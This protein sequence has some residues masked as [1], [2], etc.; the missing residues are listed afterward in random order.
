MRSAQGSVWLP[1]CHSADRGPHRALRHRIPLLSQWPLG[2]PCL[3]Q[4][5]CANPITCTIHHA[6]PTNASIAVVVS[7][8]KSETRPRT[9]TRSRHLTSRFTLAVEHTHTRPRRR[10]SGRIPRYAPFS[11][12]S[13][14]INAP[15]AS[16]GRPA[17]LYSTCLL[18]Y[19]PHIRR[20]HPPTHTLHASLP[21]PGIGILY[22]T[23]PATPARSHP[24]TR[25]P[26]HKCLCLCL[27]TYTAAIYIR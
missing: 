15:L 25:P 27:C 3:V 6:N 16:C 17:A 13:P 23:H 7:S 9:V 24:P 18:F 22:T 11:A 19:R 21:S 4:G 14:A 12:L 20:T 10:R 5:A 2:G 1:S 8:A 26:T